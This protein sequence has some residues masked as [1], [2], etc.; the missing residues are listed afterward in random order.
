MHPVRSEVMFR[1]QFQ[2]PFSSSAARLEGKE[3]GATLC[4]NASPC[5]GHS[6]R[7]PFLGFVSGRSFDKP[8]TSH[9]KQR[10]LISPRQLLDNAQQRRTAAAA[11]K[12]TVC[13][14]AFCLV[15]PLPP[16]VLL[17]CTHHPCPAPRDPTRPPSS[18]LAGLCPQL[19]PAGHQQDT[20]WQQTCQAGHRR[21]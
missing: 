20:S 16:S 13:V 1:K 5:R 14:S 11:R 18:G 9:R 17:S 21:R 2:M 3:R 12:G 15:Y 19:K 6:G 10:L 4:G 7:I 8:L